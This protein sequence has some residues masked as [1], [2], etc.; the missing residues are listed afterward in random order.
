M[1]KVQVFVVTLVLL[2]FASLANAAWV[3][4]FVHPVHTFYSDGTRTSAQAKARAKS[5][6]GKFFI[7]SDHFEQI[8]E[9]QKA[10]YLADFTGFYKGMLLIPGVEFKVPRQD[11]G[12]SHLI[13]FFELEKYFNIPPPTNLQNLIDDLSS[14][15]AVTSAAHPNW[16]D[17]IF[18]YSFDYSVSGFLGIGLFNGDFYFE[19]LKWYL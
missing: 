5:A 4:G 2:F 13:S 8:E 6:G 16:K 15:G 3:P 9:D 19:D 14:V 7:S 17:E 10:Q 18:D 11:G 1:Q 12:E